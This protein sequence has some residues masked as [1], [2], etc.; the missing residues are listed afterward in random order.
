MIFDTHCHYNLEPLYSNKKAYGYD[1]IDKISNWSDHRKIAI[2]HQVKCSLV[3]GTNLQN[4]QIAVQ[5]S[6]QDKNLFASV[7]IH[8]HEA[9][10]DNI[11]MI[12][13]L[14]NL[15]KI[16]R[17]CAIGE[18]G[19]DYY[20]LPK[21]NKKHIIHLQQVL[22][23]EQ[24]KLANKYNL[25]VIIHVRDQKEKAYTDCLKI[26][27]TYFAFKN[28]NAILHCLSGSKVYVKKA[29]DMNFYFG[30]AGNITYPQSDH[31][32]SLL[33]IIPKNRVLLETDAPFLAPG[34]Y[35]G[36]LC[37]PWMIS[38]TA[39]YLLDKF[40]ISKFQTF[41]NALNAFGIQLS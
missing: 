28:N 13:K 38:L 35:K 34:K 12:T 31:L 20:R 40:Q 6:N 25:P 32:R 26:M 23:I 11:N 9:S 4:N 27:K 33:Q 16:N 24:I 15:I 18:I 30:V 21:K 1:S 19:L 14:E 29:I 8:P 17:V 10:L 39:D 22:F 41:D 3:V 5:I 36:Q 37:E 2:K 7:G